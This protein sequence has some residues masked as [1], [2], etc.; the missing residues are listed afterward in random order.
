MTNFTQGR[1]LSNVQGEGSAD[2]N[3][4]KIQSAA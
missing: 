3:K 1:E 4:K 2:V